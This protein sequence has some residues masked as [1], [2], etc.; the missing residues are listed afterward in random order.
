MYTV[1]VK[2]LWGSVS[3]CNWPKHQVCETRFDRFG[4]LQV[5]QFVY[6]EQI[7]N[8][9]PDSCLPT[10]WQKTRFSLLEL[11]DHRCSNLVVC[12]YIADYLFSLSN[13]RVRFLAEFL[14]IPANQSMYV[15][16]NGYVI[17]LIQLHNVISETLM[18]GLISQTQGDNKWN[19]LASDV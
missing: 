17:N 4:S 19:W 2:E 13:T 16:W 7:H 3:S 5:L 11:P 10:I 9:T 18:S 8:K 15:L 12:I 6:N 14:L 1:V